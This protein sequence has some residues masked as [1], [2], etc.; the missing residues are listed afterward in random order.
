MSK[1]SY[2]SVRYN[3]FGLKSAAAKP[4]A[5]VP[6]PNSKT[7]LFYKYYF[8]ICLFLSQYAARQSAPSQT[9]PA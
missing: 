7:F 5:P 2:R 1:Y 4:R 3:F 6:E 9:V 8:A